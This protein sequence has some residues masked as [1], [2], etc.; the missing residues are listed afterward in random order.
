MK[1]RKW[2]SS[3]GLSNLTPYLLPAA[4]SA[5]S[6]LFIAAFGFVLPVLDEIS[7][8]R[9]H[10][11]CARG[12]SHCYLLHYIN[13]G[14]WLT[15]LMQ[16]DTKAALLV[17]LTVVATTPSVWLQFVRRRVACVCRFAANDIG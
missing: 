6:V 10:E 8:A 7:M 14:H 9:V 5:I 11:S 1:S 3:R 16:G 4:Y 13:G 2:M 15:L 12:I 17:Q